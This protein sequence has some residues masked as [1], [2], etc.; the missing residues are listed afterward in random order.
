M[1]FFDLRQTRRAICLLGTL[2]ATGVAAHPQNGVLLGDPNA[3]DIYQLGCDS[4]TESLRFSVRALGKG[5]A[6]TFMVYK[7]SAARATTDSNVQDSE[8]SPEAE[9]AKGSGNYL[10]FVLKG[11][12]K[13]RRSYG[14]ESHC[15]GGGTHTDGTGYSTIQNQ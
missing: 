12:K 13:G 14:L 6:P 2:Y 10:L 5:P 1:I 7:D 9:L 3:V 4:G 15:W 8:F 11:G